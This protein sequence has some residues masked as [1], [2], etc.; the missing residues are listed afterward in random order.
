MA[1]APCSSFRS[2]EDGERSDFLRSRETTNDV[3]KE[4]VMADVIEWTTARLGHAQL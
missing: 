2:E 1:A 3:D 4:K